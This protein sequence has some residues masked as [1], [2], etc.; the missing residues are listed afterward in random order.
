MPWS[1]VQTFDEK[2]KSMMEKSHKKIQ[3]GQG[4]NGTPKEEKSYICK[5]CGKEARSNIISAHIES[6]HLE[7]ISIP[8]DFCDKKF[9]SRAS[10]KYHR[11][12]FHK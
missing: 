1:P 2:V 3:H 10:V 6:N 5:V 12:K 11:N 9:S 8:C 4:P 7:E